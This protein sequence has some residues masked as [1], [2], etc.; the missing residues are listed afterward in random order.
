MKVKEI[1]EKLNKISPF[2]L[3]EGWD[4]SGLLVGE[5]ED[6]VK[7]VYLS[8]DIDESVIEE[9]EE[10]SLL[11]THHPLI[12]KPLKNVVGESFSKKFLKLLVKKNI[13]LISMHTNFDKTHLN[14]YFAEEVLGFK[15]NST[16]FIYLAEVDMK[17]EELAELVKKRMNLERVRVTKSKERV[18]KVAVTTGSGM[19]LLDFID[20]DCF[21]TGDIKYHEAMDAK[22]RG[23]S[24]IDIEH[25]HSEKY[26]VEA[27]FEEIKDFEVEIIKLNSKNPFQFM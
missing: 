2:E 14:R 12:F 16:D 23:I 10:N 27:M 20:A 13:A 21:L 18:S 1:Y 8:L 5:F 4:N 24:L 6:E 9:M 3:Q 15:G 17:F 25:F 7:K 22:S 26:F 11:I 19:G